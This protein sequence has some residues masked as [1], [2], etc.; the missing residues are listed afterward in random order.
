[1]ASNEVR[2]GAYLIP[3]ARIAS[4]SA[5]QWDGRLVLHLFVHDRWDRVTGH[6]ATDRGEEMAAIEQWM[7]EADVT[8]TDPPDWFAEWFTPRNA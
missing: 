5:G 2:C 4:V 1:M 7:A 8:A 6:F 3:T